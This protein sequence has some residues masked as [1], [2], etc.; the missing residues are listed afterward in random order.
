MR[1]TLSNFQKTL[2]EA[3]AQR[4]WKLQR[5]MAGMG[6]PVIIGGFKTGD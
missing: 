4:N 3:L 6:Q 1:V 2:N 5:L